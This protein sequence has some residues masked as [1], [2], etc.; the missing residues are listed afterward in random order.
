MIA[1]RY[2]VSVRPDEL[3]DIRDDLLRALWAQN[4]RVKQRFQFLGLHGGRG[5]RI[6]KWV[7]V[8]LSGF[9]LALSCL[10]VGL[11][12]ERRI[13]PSAI[14]AFLALGL[15]FFSLPRIEA[16]FERLTGRLLERVVDRQLT[17][18]RSRLP[19]TVEYVLDQDRVAA[20]WTSETPALS[21][22]RERS[23]VD[24]SYGGARILTGF[25][26]RRM[27]SPSIILFLPADM[28]TRTQVLTCFNAGPVGSEP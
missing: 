2:T 6:V 19:G 22:E 7:G 13:G 21:W 16:Y 12:P 11:A 23:C 10:L 18:I 25:S 20:T 1:L 27:Q 14:A 9:G 26:K 24:R 15:I 28:E 17:L 4:H 8:S 3:D 5:T